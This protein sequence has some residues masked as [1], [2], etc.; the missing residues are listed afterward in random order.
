MAR[1]G[2]VLHNTYMEPTAKTYSELQVAYDTFNAAL[3]DSALPPCLLTLQREKRTYG[4]FSARRFGTRSGQT[5]DEIALNPEYFA[6]VP[7]VEVLQTVAHEMTHLW[8]SHF[9]KPGRARYH[10]AEWADKMESIGLMPSS[11]GQPGGRRVGDCMA[12]YVI[13]NGRFATVVE[14]LLNSKRFGITWFDRFT[15]SAPLHPVASMNDATGMPEQAYAVPAVEG[16]PVVPKTPTLSAA[17]DRSNRVK[18]TCSGCGLNVWGKPTIR[19]GCL[20]CNIELA[21]ASTDQPELKQAQVHHRQHGRGRGPG[22]GIARATTRR[23]P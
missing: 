19:V 21:A 12:D 16:V 8:Q 6:L 17:K 3:F 9:G 10:N 5:T 15:P 2:C 18:Y 22:S 23:K 20:A 4:Y 11:T 14:E 1:K 13:P 7:V